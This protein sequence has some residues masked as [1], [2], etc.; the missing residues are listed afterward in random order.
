MCAV[1]VVLWVVGSLMSTHNIEFRKSPPR[2]TSP[3]GWLGMFFEMW[4]FPEVPHKPE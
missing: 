4:D 1:I 2:L 3:L